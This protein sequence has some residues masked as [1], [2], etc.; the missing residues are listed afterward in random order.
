MTVCFVLS[1]LALFLVSCSDV[2]TDAAGNLLPDEFSSV[3]YAQDSLDKDMVRI[4]AQGGH[5]TLGS[6]DTTVK[7]N[8]RTKMRVV[9]FGIEYANI[10]T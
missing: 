7:V 4:Y 10:Y 2:Y 3:G 8:E 6:D 9:P 1:V 5:V